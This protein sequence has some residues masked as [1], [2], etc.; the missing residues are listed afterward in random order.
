[1]I[2]VHLYVFIYLH[3]LLVLFLW[4][5]LT[6]FSI[7]HS[8]QQHTVGAQQGKMMGSKCFKRRHGNKVSPTEDTHTGCSSL[9][10]HLPWFRRSPQ[11]LLTVF[12]YT[13]RLFFIKVIFFNAEFDFYAFP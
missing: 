4:G 7:L 5:T 1:M 8:S 3:A 2:K 12:G 6:I 9:Q 13:L 11:S 10:E